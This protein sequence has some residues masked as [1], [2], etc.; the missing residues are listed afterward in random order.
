MADMSREELLAENAALKLERE[1][2][3][4]EMAELRR[5]LAQ[6]APPSPARRAQR[7]LARPRLGLWQGQQATHI[8][9]ARSLRVRPEH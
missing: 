2:A 8:G 1:A 7:L 4:A 5:E 9:R 3:K 6:R